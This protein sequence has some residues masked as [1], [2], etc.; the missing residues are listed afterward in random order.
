MQTK[1]GFGAS[2][3]HALVMGARAFI[4]CNLVLEFWFL[5]AFALGVLASLRETLLLLL[6]VKI[7]INPTADRHRQIDQIVLV[8]QFFFFGRI[9]Q[10]SDF[11]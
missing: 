4:I 2:N 11:Y 10:V 3:Y 1:G 6:L 9:G 7:F 5:H 8:T